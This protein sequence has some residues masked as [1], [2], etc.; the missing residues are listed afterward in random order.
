M[1]YELYVDVLFLVNFFM[2]YFLLLFIWKVLHCDTKHLNIIIGA[3][4]GAIVTCVLIILPI[5]SAFL[6]ML[7]FHIIVNTCMI[8][9]GLKIKN[10]SVFA[11]AFVLLYIGGVL[12]GG[13]LE[14]INQYVKMGSLFLIFALGGYYISLGIWNFVSKL[15]RWNQCHVRVRIRFKNQET[16]V[17]ALIDTGNSLYDSLTG[18]PVSIVAREC[19]KGL[20]QDSDVLRYISLQTLTNRESF[21]PIICV[22]KIWIL[23]EEKT[24]FYQV[25]F[26]VADEEFSKNRKYQVILNPNLF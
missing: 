13:I 9:V 8:Q 20:L 21:L 5:S 2:D 19:V 17:D 16:E 25:M 1:Y 7:L 14:S 3:A 26:A 18:K 11:R 22:E 10:I 24:C 23:N 12:M 15:H 6:E 4:V